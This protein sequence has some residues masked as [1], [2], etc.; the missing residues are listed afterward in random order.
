MYE[1]FGHKISEEKRFVGR[2]WSR[3]K[4]NI[5]SDLKVMRRKPV[6]QGTNQW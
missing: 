6:V 1:S 5:E 2:S 3:W 4:D